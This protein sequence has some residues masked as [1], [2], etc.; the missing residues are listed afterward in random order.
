MTS[1]ALGEVRAS[2]RH[3]LTNNHPVPTSPFR[4]EAPVIRFSHV[5][6]VFTNIQVHIHMTTRPETTIC[7]SHKELLRAG[8]EPTTRCAKA[9]YPATAPTVQSICRCM[10]IKCYVS[11]IKGMSLSSPT[12]SMIKTSIMYS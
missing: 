12:L 5:V 11:P 2:V 8:I 10:P 9:V 4:A 6:G 1:P 7:G 3:L